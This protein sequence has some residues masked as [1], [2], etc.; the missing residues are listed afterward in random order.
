VAQ[1]APIERAVFSD[2]WSE[3]DLS[4][5]VRTG[6]PFLVAEQGGAV[7]GYVIAHH[8][9]DEAEILN[10]GVV[11]SRQ[12][13]GVGRA[14][15]QGMLAQLRQQGVAT[16]FLE[17]RESNTVAQ[18]LYGALGFAHVGRRRAYYRFPTEDAVVLRATI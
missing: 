15:V 9:L 14:L 17:V 5:C 1:V 13:Q 12:R 3:R 11:P 18:R 4:D 6:V 8:A 7:V 16:V 2:P 10:L